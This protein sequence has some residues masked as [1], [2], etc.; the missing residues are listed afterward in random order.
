MWT[1]QQG[2]KLFIL[3]YLSFVQYECDTVFQITPTDFRNTSPYQFS[4]SSSTR[5]LQ[6]SENDH[7]A[8]HKI[9]QIRRQ[10]NRSPKSRNAR[11]PAQP[12]APPKMKKQEIRTSEEPAHHKG[13]PLTVKE[14]V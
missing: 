10:E 9:A 3:F 5:L 8:A 12:H 13:K 7:I 2:C 4:I 11:S 1:P 6:Y 14:D